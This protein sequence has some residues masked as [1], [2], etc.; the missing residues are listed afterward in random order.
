MG[1]PNM[2][3]LLGGGVGPIIDPAR[4]PRAARMVGPLLLMSLHDFIS[5]DF[6]GVVFMAK[7]KEFLFGR[8]LSGHPTSIKSAAGY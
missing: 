3:F 8:T 6:D 2:E 4:D 7:G 5:R 1:H